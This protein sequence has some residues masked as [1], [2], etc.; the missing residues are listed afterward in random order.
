[1]SKKRIF[2]KKLRGQWVKVR[3]VTVKWNPWM[4]IL[5]PSATRLK[6]SFTSSSGK[7]KQFEIFHWLTKNCCAAEMKITKLYASHLT[8]GPDG[9]WR[10][11]R[12]TQAKQ[13]AT[14]CDHSRSIDRYFVADHNPRNHKIKFE[15]AVGFKKHLSCFKKSLKL[16]FEPSTLAM[17]MWHWKSDRRWVWFFFLKVP[18]SRPV[19]D[20]SN[21]K[22]IDVKIVKIS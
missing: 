3:S 15:S 16:N 17:Q 2:G 8:S 14:Y 11:L 19:S 21:P 18:A 6:M 9:R 1:M 20:S 5:V 7:T 13:I 4:H 10:A 22:Y 12:K